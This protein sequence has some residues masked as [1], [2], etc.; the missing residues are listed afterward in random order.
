MKIQSINKNYNSSFKAATVNINSFSDTHG[1]LKL[2]NNALEEMRKR[3][4][5]IFCK[6]GRGKANVLAVCGDWFID[7]GRTGYLSNPERANAMF[8]LDIFNALIQGIKSL[9][10]CKTTVLFTPGNHEFDGGVKILNDVL[11]GIDADVLMSNLDRDNSPAFAENIAGNKIVS[12]KII[13]VD[14]DKDFTKKHKLLFLGVSPV[15]M[16]AYQKNMS[17]VAL[18][19][20]SSKPQ[21]FLKKD[22]YQKTLDY[23]K[24]KISEFKKNNPDGLVVLLCHTGAGFADN[25]ASE[26]HLDLVLDGHEHKFGV[27]EVNGTKIVPLSQNFNNMVNVKLMINDAGLLHSMG[28]KYYSPLQNK[29]IGPLRKFYDRLFKKDI[30]NV[31]SIRTVNPEIKSLDVQNIRYGNN[32]LANFVVDSVMAGV[33]EKDSSVDFL[34]LNS[35]SIRHSLKVSDS[36]SVSN[37]DVLNVLSGIKEEEGQM[38][39]TELSGAEL[40]YIVVDNFVFNRKAPAS[41]PLIHYSGLI[42]DRTAILKGYDSGK[43]PEELTK[44]IIDA[45]TMEPVSPYKKYKIANVEKYFNKSQNDFIRTLKGKSYRL[46]CTVQS[47]FKDSFLNSNGLLY[48]KCDKRIF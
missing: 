34:A 17:G 38:M 27:R 39:I 19:E 36:P 12:E 41:N 5:D 13:E 11:S 18:F 9:S 32:F 7:G 20:N 28:I 4:Q 23:C 29:V 46:G 22:D 37:F 16:Y 14:D 26:S 10:K 31:Y 33:K 15:N 40:A 47:L 30:E 44:Y 45:N 6:Q 42:I 1:E 8:Q 21:K 3:K 48:A 2:A 25:L 43:S 35:S 24:D